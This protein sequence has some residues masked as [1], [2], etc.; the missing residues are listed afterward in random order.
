MGFKEITDKDLLVYLIVKKFEIVE[1][2]KAQN[3][4]IFFFEDTNELNASI[5]AFVNKSESINIGDILGAERR[6][7]TLLCLQT[8]NK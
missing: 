8:Q 2:R 1:T 6:L 4:T 7:K 3:K 5:L